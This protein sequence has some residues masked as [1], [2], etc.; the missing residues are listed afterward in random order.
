VISHGWRFRFFPTALRVSTGSSIA[1]DF[2]WETLDFFSDPFILLPAQSFCLKLSQM[3]KQFLNTIHHTRNYL[4]S[5]ADVTVFFSL[6][7]AVEFVKRPTLYAG[8]GKKLVWKLIFIREDIGRWVAAP[9][10]FEVVSM[11]LE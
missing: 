9:K 4:R 5:S 2:T 3:Q 8:S 6:H 1:V 11:P 10:Y 7:Q